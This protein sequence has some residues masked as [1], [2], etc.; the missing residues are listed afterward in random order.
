VEELRDEGAER[1]P[2]EDD[3]ALGAERAAGTDRNRGRHGLEHGDLRVDAAS[4]HENGLD[5]LGDAVTANA[6]RPVTGHQ[7]DHQAARDWNSDD[8]R[9]EMV[10]RRRHQRR[11]HALKE[12]QICEEADELE[13]PVRHVGRDAADEERERRDGQ[14]AWCR[15]EVPE[16]VVVVGGFWLAG[17]R[18]RGG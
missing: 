15:G 13:Q 2:G 11:A 5:R 1:A 10:S 9:P 3:R 4:A 12:E 14:K 17:A 7:A 8:P 18:R 16:V 6:V